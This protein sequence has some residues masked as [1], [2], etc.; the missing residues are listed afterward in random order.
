MLARLIL[1]DSVFDPDDFADAEI[2]FQ[3]LFNLLPI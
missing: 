1:I 2:C 3:R